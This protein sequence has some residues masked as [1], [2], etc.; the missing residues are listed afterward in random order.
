MLITDPMS[1]YYLTDVYVQPMERFY[2]LLLK[3]NGDHIFSESSVF[4]IGSHRST[5]GMVLRYRSGNGQSSGIYR[6]GRAAGSG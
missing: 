3:E 6:P 2:A 1:V 5:A 4:C